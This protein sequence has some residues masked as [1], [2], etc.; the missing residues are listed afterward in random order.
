MEESKVYNLFIEC[1]P[2][3]SQKSSRDLSAMWN[4]I[5]KMSGGYADRR[6]PLGRVLSYFH[7]GSY[8]ES[9]MYEGHYP[10]WVVSH[11]DKIAIVAYDYFPYVIFA[12]IRNKIE[13]CRI[14]CE[15]VTPQCAVRYSDI[16]RTPFHNLAMPNYPDRYGV[17]IMSRNIEGLLLPFE[18]LHLDKCPDLSDVEIYFFTEISKDPQDIREVNYKPKRWWP[19]YNGSDKQLVLPK[20]KRF[21]FRK[22]FEDPQKAKAEWKEQIAR[23]FPT[24]TPKA[25]KA[26]ISTADDISKSIETAKEPV[27]PNKSENKVKKYLKY[28]CLAYLVIGAIIFLLAL[29]VL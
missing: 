12:G 20:E 14:C 27:T 19:D 2:G 5:Y 28:G 18:K 4:D 13:Y 6:I 25:P 15:I 21:L 9:D 7:V 1:F 11:V 3:A 16:E 26:S 23:Q 29:C 24:K 17:S 8:D 10:G 22:F